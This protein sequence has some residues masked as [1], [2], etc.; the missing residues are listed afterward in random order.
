MIDT[1]QPRKPGLITQF[2]TC[3]VYLYMTIMVLFATPYFNWQYASQHGFIQWLLFGEVVPTTKAM[4]WPYF[5]YA[6][7]SSARRAA[8]ERDKEKVYLQASEPIGKERGALNVYIARESGR[9]EELAKHD[10]K[11]AL[12]ALVS[13]FDTFADK[14]AE[15]LARL[16]KLRPPSS[17]AEVHNITVEGT[18]G[19]IPL[20]RRMV[21]L[22]KAGDASGFQS[23]YSQL[24]NYDAEWQ[25]RRDEKIPGK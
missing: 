23:A 6:D 7:I 14:N 13:L 15:L 3:I 4:I 12:K 17:L 1:D 2:A 5:V 20:I 10:R 8:E 24:M 19:E 21:S 16:E 22:L 9:I 11:A 18:R 25:K